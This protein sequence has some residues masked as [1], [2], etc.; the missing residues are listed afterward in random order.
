MDGQKYLRK[1]SCTYCLQLYLAF[2]IMAGAGLTPEIIPL[3][4][5]GLA[6]VDQAG[7][8]SC[9][10]EDKH[11]L[12]LRCGHKDLTPSITVTVGHHRNASSLW[13]LKL[14]AA[15]PSQQDPRGSPARCTWSSCQDSAVCLPPGRSGGSSAELGSGQ[16]CAGLCAALRVPQHGQWHSRAQPPPSSA[17]HRLVQP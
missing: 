17:W 3:S 2:S 15:K 9:L 11:G 16:G 8:F 13:S 14:T 5:L 1:S 10:V 7:L 12:Q 6:D 4:L